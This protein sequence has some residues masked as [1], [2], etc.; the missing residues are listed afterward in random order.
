MQILFE[1]S[2]ESPNIKGLGIFKGSVFKFK[3]GKIPQIGWN[4]VEFNKALPNNYFYFVN[5]YYCDPIDEK[6]IF[7]KSDYGRLFACAIMRNNIIGTQFHIEKSGK[8]GIDFFKW[9]LR[10]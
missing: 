2:E 8:A 6:I 10:C 7:G 9:W 1:S 4:I 5:S 3:K